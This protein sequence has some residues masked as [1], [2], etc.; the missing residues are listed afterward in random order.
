MTHR[1]IDEDQGLETT[2]PTKGEA[3][4][5]LRLVARYDAMRLETYRNKEQLFG[6]ICVS[7][8]GHALGLRFDDVGYFNRVYC[9]DLSF[10]EELAAIEEFYRGGRFGCEVVGPPTGVAQS[11]RLARAGWSAGQEY[12]WLHHANCGALRLGDGMQFT[13]RPPKASEQHEFLQAYLCAFEAQ[14]EN[15]PGALRNMKHLFDRPELTFLMAW[16]GNR[17]AGIAMWMRCG[18]AA[19]LCAGAALPEFRELGCHAALLGA[20][21]R[22]AAEAGCKEIYSWAALGGQS[23]SN[24]ERAGLRVVGTTKTWRYRA[25]EGR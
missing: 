23:Q 7:P 3:V 17:L 6:R 15:I 1:P 12:A 11:V 13:I 25:E 18:E 5:A 4:R 2:A 20:R 22:M 9:D 16:Q 24:M 14:R 19:L 10:V 8:I 21:I